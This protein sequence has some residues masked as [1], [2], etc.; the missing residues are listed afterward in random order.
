MFEGCKTSPRL[1][2]QH[3]AAREMRRGGMPFKQ[4][5]AALGVS[6]ATVHRWT[7]DIQL[8]PTQRAAIERQ[9]AEQWRRTVERR[10]VSWAAT[11]RRRRQEWQEQGRR[12]ARD[13]DP[14]HLAG[15]M[16]YWCEGDKGRNTMRLVNSD[17]PMITFFARFARE[18]LGVVD[19]RFVLSLN[20]YLG[21]GLGIGEIEDHWLSA[22]RLDRTALRKH[23]LNHMP[24]SSSGRKRNKLPYGVCSLGVKRSTDLVQHIF[25]AIQ[26]YAGFEEPRW[27][28]G[29]Y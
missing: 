12:A 24:T 3:A 21:N 8:T 10:A 15:C 29:L 9:A 13:G 2:H 14:L 5:A 27:L 7:K 6:P 16:L 23:Q 25:G 20:V 17:L 19:A 11:C 26:E 1:P 28:D 4:I 18:S 22:L